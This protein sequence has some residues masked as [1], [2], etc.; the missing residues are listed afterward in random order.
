MNRDRLAEPTFM[1]GR[2]SGSARNGIHEAP[3][4]PW[5]KD[6]GVLVAYGSRSSCE[7]GSIGSG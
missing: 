7:S 2:Q 1:S 6:V 5:G 4:E 3:L